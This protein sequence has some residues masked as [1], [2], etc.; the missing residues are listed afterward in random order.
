MLSLTD[1][2]CRK[3]LFVTQAPLHDVLS[4]PR[5]KGSHP[6]AWTPEL[7][8]FFKECRQSL[9][10]ATLLVHPEPSAQL[11]LVTDAST[12]AIGAVLQQH[13]H[14]AWQPLAF[15]SKKLNTTKQKYSAYDRELLAAL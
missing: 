8:K 5:V 6:I 15:F 14:N 4:S 2:F 7:H 9:S 12:T 11:A 3:L 10:R 1:D 13:V